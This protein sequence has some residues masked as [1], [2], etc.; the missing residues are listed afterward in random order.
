M[1]D[2]SQRQALQFDRE[3]MREFGYQVI[4][5]LVDYYESRAEKPVAEKLDLDA[6]DGILTEPLPHEPSHWRA[7]LEQFERQVVDTS[8]RVD[9]PR[10]FA[11][12]PLANNF[13]SV[14]ADALAAGYN[15]FNAVWLQGPGAAQ[16]E[17]LTVDWLRQIFGFPAAAGG[18]FVS[19]GSVANL[20]ALAVAREIQLRGDMREAVAYCSDQIHFAVSRGLRLLGFA[21]GQLRKIP[22]DENFRLPLEALRAA[23]AEDRAAG[24]R[25]FCVIASAGTT[26]TGAVDPLDA[27]A[28]L[29]LDENLWLHVDGAYGAPAVLTPQGAE[30]LKGLERAHSLALDAHKWLF[31]PIECSVV[32]LRDRHWLPA[33]FK[34]RA[35]YLKDVEAE[36]EEINFMYQGIQLTR[37]FRALKLWMSFKV[38]G[39]DAISEAIAAGFAN[40]E[41][42][43]RLLRAAGCWE[44]VTPA[45]MAI[46]T[47][48]YTPANGDQTLAD[49]VTQD[50]VERLRRDGDAF[51]SGTQL[52]GKPVMR[53]CANNPRTTPADLE[54]TIQLMGRLAAELEV[55]L[56]GL[57]ADNQQPAHH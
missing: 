12:I 8:N 57:P 44:I 24:R 47:F 26:N 10:F 7:V 11:Y 37:Q 45:G 40:A 46:V 33:T 23:I 14:M 31:Q 19:G 48:R 38:F 13:A 49:R 51:A 27:L 28:D 53:L 32:L 56:A 34:E 54:K 4:D 16:I 15:I 20:T 21:P 2:S 35:E 25:P 36:G 6:L 3:E 52:R 9:H 30:A 43:E 42:A 17:R 39:L 41:L 5:S 55:Q 1:S 22:S 50:L 18:T 29:C